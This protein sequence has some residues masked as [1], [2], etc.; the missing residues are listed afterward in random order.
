MEE[1]KKK[2]FGDRAKNADEEAGQLQEKCKDCV[3]WYVK[4]GKYYC[5]QVYCIKTDIGK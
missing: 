1:Y 2:S 3:N 5:S 4:D